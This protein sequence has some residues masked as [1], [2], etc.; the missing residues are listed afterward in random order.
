MTYDYDKNLIKESLT[1]DQV[2]DLL[3]EFGGEPQRN[4]NIIISKTI[5]HNPCHCGNHK[6]YYYENSH[7]F[8]CYT[9]CGESWDIFELTRKVMSREHPKSHNIQTREGT[10]VSTEWNLPEAIDFIARK[11]G[12]APNQ[13]EDDF[14]LSIKDDLKIFDRYDRIKDINK[15]T[16]KVELKE[17]EGNFLKHL[18]HPIIF[19]WI[20]EGITQEVMNIH[21]ICYNPVNHAIV[22]PHYD[23]NGRLI[24]I[25]ERTLIKEN[26]VYGKYKPAYIGQ[27]MYNHPLSFNLY[28]LNISKENI[29]RMKK[30]FVFEG[31]KSCLL[32][33][34]YFGIENDLSVA[35]CGS[36]FINYQ[37]WLLIEQG[38][39]EIIICFD[40]QFQEK[41]D[42]EFKKLTKNLTNIHNKY[43]KY[44]NIS[45]IF[46]KNNL[47]G[48]KSSPVDEGKEKFLQLY[49]ERI[50]LY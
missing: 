23:I 20:K 19:P 33:G 44:I 38:A 21:D 35:V 6:L 31:E 45:I 34:S 49:K 13:N 11:F 41:G 43:G 50:N 46:D 3:V 27:K 10:F 26:E 1:I 15:L 48:Y 8:H 9:D 12:F 5:C 36:S 4:G 17:Y 47:L 24:G 14:D 16:Q 42:D 40:K 37:A 2:E 30:V 32:F 18:P 28:N 39:E 25:R 29:S 7:L 22:I